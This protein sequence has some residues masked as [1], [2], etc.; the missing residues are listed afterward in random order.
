MSWRDILGVEP[1]S[2]SVPQNPHKNFTRQLNSADS[3]DYAQ[4]DALVEPT[5]PNPVE[6]PSSPQDGRQTTPITQIT[7]NAENVANTTI[8]AESAGISSN[9]V[10]APDLRHSSCQSCRHRTPMKSCG[11]PVHAGLSEQFEIRWHP[12]DGRGCTA[13]TPHPPPIADEVIWMDGKPCNAVT[14]P[15]RN[16]LNAAV[17]YVEDT[18]MSMVK[19]SS[20]NVP[21]DG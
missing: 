5:V 21:S 1:R 6:T 8:C 14:I 19:F 3:A 4:G 11:D 18:S 2:A 13:W 12:E 9:P 17:G 10:I 16:T 7:H 20:K 15:P